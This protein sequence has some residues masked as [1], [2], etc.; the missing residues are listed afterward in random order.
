MI[1]L[2]ATVKKETRYIA[3]VTVILSVLM[4]AVF[5]VLGAFLPAAKWDYTVLLGNILGGGVAVLNF[6]GLGITVQKAIEKDEKDA[7]S[8]M[9]ASQSIR[10][11]LMF[12]IAVLGLVIGCFNA[13]AT[14]VPLFFP[15]IAIMFKPIF[16]KSSN[17]KEGE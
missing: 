9:R 15:R 12:G 4:Q 6:L 7:K 13:V 1:K 3:A 16:E 11:F 10:T 17:K 2:D 5:L 8:M 14:I